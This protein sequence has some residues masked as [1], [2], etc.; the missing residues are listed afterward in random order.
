MI[1]FSC[2]LPTDFSGKP[3]TSREA[4]AHGLPKIRLIASGSRSLRGFRRGR[5]SPCL[6]DQR[7]P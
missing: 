1:F 5:F 7:A 6:A 4:I 2:V 3:S